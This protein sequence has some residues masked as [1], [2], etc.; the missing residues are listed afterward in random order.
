[1]H[2]S[3]SLPIE[4]QPT[5]VNATQWVLAAKKMGAGAAVMTAR[6]EGGFALWP[7]KFTNCKYITVPPCLLHTLTVSSFSSLNGIRLPAPTDS[8][9]YSPYRGGKGDIVMEFVTACRA[10]GIKPGLYIAGGC[11]AYHH[12]GPHPVTS[13]A[14]YE[15]IQ[16]GMV[17]ELVSGKY[18]VI[19]YLWFDH[20]GN[21]VNS[22]SPFGPE[23]PHM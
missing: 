9:A 19:E 13:A 17:E 5:A 7:S 20:H 14:E 21:P 10:H 22:T 1:V 16:N 11:D 15:R 6:H 4:L 12:C 3:Y 18:G 23:C 2:S 8:I